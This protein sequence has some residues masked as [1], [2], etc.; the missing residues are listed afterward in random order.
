MPFGN[1]VSIA[2]PDGVIASQAW[3]MDFVK[4]RGRLVTDYPGVAADGTAD[5]SAALPAAV[6]DIHAAGLVAVIPAGVY[7]VSSPITLDP[8]VGSVIGVGQV[9]LDGQ[10]MTSGTLLTLE[11]SA[12][13]MAFR[14]TE[15]TVAGLRLL[16]PSAESATV[17]GMRFVGAENSSMIQVRDC[18]WSGFRDSVVYGNNTWNV[19][20]SRCVIGHWTRRA[21]NLD[22][23]DNAGE[24]Y[25][26]DHCTFF[27]GTNSTGDATAVYTSPTGDMDASFYSCS[28]DYNDRAVFHQGG[29]LWF[30]G[31]HWEGNNDEP[32]ILL[33]RTSDP[34]NPRTTV[35]MW[36]GVFVTTEPGAGRPHLIEVPAS[37]PATDDIYL[38][39]FGAVFDLHNR[40]TDVFVNKSSAT[41]RV[42]HEGCQL[43]GTGDGRG[44]SF[45]AGTNLLVNGDMGTASFLAS[46]AFPL[47][48]GQGWAR[49]GAVVY[50]FDTAES[51]TSPQS[52]KMQGTGVA[53]G[54][55]LKQMIA[56]IPGREL[57]VT[58]VMKAP[59]IAAGTCA[60]RL[61][62]Y[63]ADHSTRQSVV[64]SGPAVAS[65]SDWT[66]YHARKIVPPGITAALVEIVNTN[67]DGTVY[68]DRIRAHMT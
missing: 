26:W 24:N 34:A 6:A 30:Y 60:A 47:Y 43:S 9:V 29:K 22:A 1:P 38:S 32:F 59:V 41:P 44:A 37:T 56:V 61:S 23:V 54:T 31:C 20:M 57:L 19:Q 50:T 7:K 15:Q 35:G 14:A 46:S 65:G 33:T 51:F 36:G 21:L 48:P 49:D 11:C 55:S 10:G 12:P 40:W 4:G 42:M 25:R 18:S 39:M 16:G 45:G 58:W 64:Y 52:V 3:T 28:F 63:L 66:A 27:N 68:A 13:G 8:S 67:L 17:D 53:A 5:V 62:W 2:L